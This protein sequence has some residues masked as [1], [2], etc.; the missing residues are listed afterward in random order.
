MIP[1]DHLGL[2]SWNS[3]DLDGLR[4]QRPLS[5]FIL[6][7]V[8]SCRGDDLN[9]DGALSLGSILAA[10]GRMAPISS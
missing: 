7:N 1:A 2:R 8:V 10:L 6:S 3:V 9:N 5:S 4:V